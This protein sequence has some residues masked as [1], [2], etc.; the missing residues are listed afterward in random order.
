MEPSLIEALQREASSL[1]AELAESPVA[2]RL[3]IVER[4]LRAIEDVAKPVQYPAASSIPQAAYFALEDAKEPM[5][6]VELLDIIKRYGRSLRAAKPVWALSN[7]LSGDPR[8]VSVPWR[9]GRAWWFADRP[10]PD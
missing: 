10:T 2:Q 1:R 9:F 4:T 6:T 8:F 3:A 7:T 5:R